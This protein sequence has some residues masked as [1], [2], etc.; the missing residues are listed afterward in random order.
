MRKLIS[1]FVGPSLPQHLRKAA[2]N[3]RFLPPARAGDMLALSSGASHT[4]LLVDGLFEQARAPWH[5]EILVLMSRGFD[6]WGAASLGA[7]RAAELQQFGMR[8]SGGIARAYCTGRI[9]GDDEVAVAHAPAALGFAALSVAQVDVRATLVSAV[10]AGVLSPAE[11]RD[12]RT[13][14]HAIFFKERTWAGVAGAARHCLVPRRHAAFAQ[15]LSSGTVQQK[16]RD[17]LAALTEIEARPAHHPAPAPPPETSFLQRLRSEI[18][19][20]PREGS[21]RKS[22]SHRHSGTAETV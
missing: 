2:Q 13:L 4:I 3:V 14:S 15:W 12:V 6:V 18:S 7:L 9:V 21:P 17:V 10:H 11:A 16:Q 22:A 19:E 1:V 20:A 8:A 5:K